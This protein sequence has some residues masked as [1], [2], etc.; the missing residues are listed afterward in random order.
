[1]APA[2]TGKYTDPTKVGFLVSGETYRLVR[3]IAADK[4]LSAAKVMEEMIE[5]AAKDEA[6]KI[7]NQATKGK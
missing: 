2:S 4:G 6:S 1:M 5:K 3:L 7:L